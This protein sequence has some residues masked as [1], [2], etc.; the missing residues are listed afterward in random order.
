MVLFVVSFKKS[1][2]DPES[3]TEGANEGES[4]S[5]NGNANIFLLS[6]SVCYLS[7][8]FSKKRLDSIRS[9]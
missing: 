1:T 6:N 3:A 8:I 7:M 5:R 2:I 9:T 4:F